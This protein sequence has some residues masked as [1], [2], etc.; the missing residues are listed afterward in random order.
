MAGANP[1]YG[2]KFGSATKHIY[3]TGNII[4]DC[5]ATFVHQFGKSVQM[6]DATAQFQFVGTAG[7]GGEGVA[8]KDSGGNTRFGLVFPGSNIVGLVNR[9]SNGVVQIRANTSTAGSG[10]EVTVATFE[11]DKYTLHLMNSAGFVKN[12][13]AG[14]LSGGN[15]VDISDDTNLSA[16]VPIVLTGDVLSHS[17][18]SGYV[19]IPAGGAS[20]Q[21]LQY[22]AAGTA[23]WITLSEDASIADG[24]AITVADDSHAHTATTLSLLGIQSLTDPN[25]DRIFFW[26]DSAGASAWLAASTGI[27]IVGTNLSTKDSEIAHDSLSGV[28][29]NVNTAGSPTFVGLTITDIFRHD[30]TTEHILIL[31]YQAGAGL[32]AGGTYNYFIGEQAGY[33]ITTGDHNLLIGYQAG[34]GI[35]GQGYNVAIGDY[36]CYYPAWHSVCIGYNAGKGLGGEQWAN[37]V[38]GS[39][40]GI[41]FTGASDNII[42]GFSSGGSI[43]SGYYNV[44]LGNYTGTKITTHVGNVCIGHGAGSEFVGSY[45]TFIGTYAGQYAVYAGTYIGLRAGEY[46]EGAGNIFLGQSA[47]RYAGAG[48]CNVLIGLDAYIASGK[49]TS[50]GIGAGVKVTD[51]HQLVFGDKDVFDA[52]LSNGYF[53]GGVVSATPPDF[54]FNATGGYGTDIGGADLIFGGGRGTGAGFGGDLIFKTALAGAS[55]NGLNA[56]IE[57]MRITSNKN[58]GIGTPDQFGSGVKVIGIANATTNPST[59][60]TGG[61]VLY[62]DAADGK[63]KY[64]S[65]SGETRILDYT[66][67]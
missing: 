56:L 43:T 8:Y 54:T 39:S 52:Y 31:G 5:A 55:G 25:A 38:I 64:R 18:A 53:G 2:I 40:S 33:S 60:P 10:G 66:V 21:L 59:N 44:L 57:A 20:A 19:H 51:N 35:V 42:V 62:P 12:T 32:L 26:D 37:T 15:K 22:S 14:L 23:K 58:L 4:Y 3:G 50:I 27:Q 7:G 49:Y 63:L 47:G 11:D 36:A 16:T 65:A 46:D 6:L 28:H 29:Q 67:A 41:K 1:Q 45:G 9:A 13:A 17:T 48:S 30:Y 61:I 24:G 34:Y